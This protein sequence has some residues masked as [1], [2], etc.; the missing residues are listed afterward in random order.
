MDTIM[1]GVGRTSDKTAIQ[2]SEGG[3]MLI[4]PWTKQILCVLWDHLRLLVHVV[5]YSFLAVFQM[6]RL[7]VHLRITDETGHRVQHVST[8]G[9]PADSFILTSLFDGNK[10]VF[11]PG[12]G[13]LSKRGVNAYA[14]S[15]HAEAL[16]SSL[17]AEDL[18]LS[19]VD[20]FVIRAKEGLSSDTDDDFCLGHH[21]SWKRNDPGD[22]EI[23]VSE[24]TKRCAEEEKEACWY[25]SKTVEAVE[26]VPE[27][28][29]PP[30]QDESFW[31][32]EDEEAGEEFDHEE[33]RALWESF[34]KSLDPYNPLSFSAC[35]S[36]FSTEAAGQEERGGSSDVS[37]RYSADSATEDSP[38]NKPFR[39]YCLDFI[40]P[41]SGSD[42]DSDWD[43]SG[44]SG[45][46][47]EEENQRLWEQFARPA[48]PYN[49]LHF[50]ACASSS[51]PRKA[52]AGG[53]E[54]ALHDCPKSEAWV[55]SDP[56]AAGSGS[57]R[58]SCSE[59]E[60]ELW[61][62]FSQSADPYHPLNFR[63]CLQSSPP[64]RERA[65]SAAPPQKPRPSKPRLP[66]RHLKLHHCLQT[67]AEHRRL[68]PWK[69]AARGPTTSLHTEEKP[70]LK[71]V[72]FSPVVQV[73]IMHTWSFASQAV[74]KGPWEEFARDRARFHRRV[75]RPKTPLVTASTNL[76]ERRS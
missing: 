4:L 31:D 44:G 61:N 41:G 55:S 62:S 10:S 20:D 73:H 22:W 34:T 75:R 68:T 74:R 26:T 69:R 7:E 63:A 45:S 12:S 52:T 8:S 53:T 38:Q 14:G 58:L 71:K 27:L 32:E 2:R 54:R 13:S 67:A 35:I 24:E 21:P 42:I 16:L 76:I 70:T 57:D 56:D 48:D 37:E 40:R 30:E 28:E 64:A 5:Y 72:R 33:S 23:R 39:K 1:E 25:D 15:S 66:K 65:P 59:E 60:A 3:G 46:E 11:I 47:D 51:G 36:T 50:T 29:T 49:P 43:C 19:L 17:G 6:F 18:C 9:N